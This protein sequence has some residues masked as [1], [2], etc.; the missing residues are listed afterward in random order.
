M[1]VANDSLLINLGLNQF[2]VVDDLVT[3]TT[4]QATAIRCPGQVNRFI[5]VVAT[6]AA[7]LPSLLSI[8][9]PTIVFVINDDAAQALKVFPTTGETLNGTLNAN[10]S[11]PAGQSGIFIAVTA[12][13]VGKGGGFAPGSFANDWRSAIIP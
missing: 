8:E 9:A 10:L 6:G 12:A 7:A 4:T 3:T 2:P 13:K 1:T 5:K 11:I